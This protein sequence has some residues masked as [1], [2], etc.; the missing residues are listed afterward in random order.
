MKKTLFLLF[1]TCAALLAGENTNLPADAAENL[2]GNGELAADQ[3]PFPAYWSNDGTFEFIRGGGPRGMN[4]VKTDASKVKTATLRQDFSMKLVPGGLYRVSMRVKTHQLKAGRFSFSLYSD[5]WRREAGVF[6]VPSDTGGKWVLLENRVY[7]AKADK[8]HGCAVAMTRGQSGWAM[9]AD[10]RIEPVS[11]KA[12]QESVSLIRGLEKPRFVPVTAL[13]EILPEKAEIRGI[14]FGKKTE[15]AAEYRIDKGAFK[16]AEIGEKGKVTLALAGVSIGAHTLE[17]KYGDFRKSWEFEIVPPLPEVPEKRL[18]N[19]VSELPPVELRE[20]KM[21]KFIL[22][23]RS[24]VYFTLP[25]PGAS[26]QVSGAKN[27]VVSKGAVYLAR[28]EHTLLLKGASGKVGI[29]LIPEVFTYQLCTGPYLRGA[30]KNGDRVVLKY[31]LPYITSYA[32][33]GKGALS[34]EG[35][36]Q[37][38]AGNYLRQCGVGVASGITSEKLVKSVNTSPGLNAPGFDGIAFDEFP[39]GDHVLMACYNE[40][41]PKLLLPPGRRF[42]YCMFGKPSAGGIITEFLSNAVNSGKGSGMIKYEAYCQPVETEAQAKEYIRNLIVETAKAFD[43]SFPGIMPHLCLYFINCNT[44]A[45][46]TSAYLPDVDMKYYLDMQ[47]NLLAND[48]ALKGVGMT[49][50]WGSNYADNEMVRWTGRLFRHYCIEGRREPLAPKYGFTYKLPFVTNPDFNDGL[51][52][53]QVEGNITPGHTKGYAVYQKRWACTAGIGDNYAV[54]TRGEKPNRLFQKL[55]GVK[56][57]RYYKLQYITADAEDV[58]MGKGGRPYEL[59]VDVQIEGAKFI[60][61]ETLCYKA[62]RKPRKIDKNM[63]KV[64]LD[65][66]IFKAEKD[67]PVITFSDE[68]VKPGRKT[69]LNYISLTPY[70]CEE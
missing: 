18:N 45:T 5:Y 2:V 36:K 59:S 19:L 11:E 62:T 26:L 51:K 39:S 67:D 38:E 65:Q 28:G 70:F 46:L 47:F 13:F 16:K 31:L 40:A 64:N 37:V 55:K 1:L 12:R 69:A 14:W 20:G 61:E 6:K 33:V 22:P 49:G 27:P 52:G 56:A 41:H 68:K 42:Y 53:W 32:Q 58:T 24:W 66:R 10:L 44:P 25:A 43:R 4:A 21:G 8:G 9:V 48:P 34:P 3:S 35:W 54:L 63:Y 50:N 60:P 7:A 23:R 29:R 30:R 17:F 15:G 57:G